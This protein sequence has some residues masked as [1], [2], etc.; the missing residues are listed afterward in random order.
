[1]YPL[2]D[3]KTQPFILSVPFIRC[4]LGGYH[5]QDS[6]GLACFDMVNFDSIGALLKEGF[7]SSASLVSPL[8]HC[9][10]YLI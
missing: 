8:S 5:E 6:Y 1:M 10:L 3:V 2:W 9:L 7:H 4:I